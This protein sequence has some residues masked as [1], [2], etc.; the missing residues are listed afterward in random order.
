MCLFRAYSYGFESI[1]I[2]ISQ[3]VLCLY[4]Q[5]PIINSN[6]I[7]INSHIEGIHASI[8][9]ANELF[10]SQ[11]NGSNFTAWYAEVFKLHT[12]HNNL[13]FALEIFFEKGSAFNKTLKK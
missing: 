10:I 4:T 2:L 5:S 8:F 12:Y 13:K 1:Q 3:Y 6:Y 9:S 11:L 7:I